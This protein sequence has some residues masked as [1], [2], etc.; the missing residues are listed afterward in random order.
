MTLTLV[1]I[2][3]KTGE[4]RDVGHASSITDAAKRLTKLAKAE[5]TALNSHAEV[6]QEKGGYCVKVA[7]DRVAI[8]TFEEL[9]F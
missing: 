1:R 6:V 7:P 5:A 4:K 8:Y 9:P 2:C 3:V